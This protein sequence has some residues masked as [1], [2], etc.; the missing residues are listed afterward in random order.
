MFANKT[1][2]LKGLEPELYKKLTRDSNVKDYKIAD[3]NKIN[4]KDDED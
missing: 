2:N 3:R 1:T 4:T